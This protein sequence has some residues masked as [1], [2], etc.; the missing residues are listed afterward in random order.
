MD[1]SP[2]ALRSRGLFS[3]LTSPAD[4]QQIHWLAV[5]RTVKINTVQPDQIILGAE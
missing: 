5:R 4:C 1:T 3:I 2:T